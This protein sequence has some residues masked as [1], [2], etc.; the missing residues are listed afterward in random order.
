M[1]NGW[2]WALAFGM[3]VQMVTAAPARAQDQP[4]AGP[5]AAHDGAHGFD[6]LLGSWHYHLQR[7]QHPVT[8]STTWYKFDG[9]GSCYRLWDGAQ[10]DTFEVNG[11]AGHIEGITLRLYDRKTAQWRLY[12][13]NSQVGVLDPPQV[14]EFRNGHGDFFTQDTIDGKTILI[15]FDWTRM[16]SSAPH[17]E[18]AFSADG[19]TTWD[20]NWITDQ[21]RTADAPVWDPSHP[22]PPDA[23]PAGPAAA[24]DPQHDFD[25]DRG[26]WKIHIH[27]LLHPLTGSNEWTDMDGATVT[28][29][30]WNGRANLATVEA[31]G[32]T[33][34]L[35]LLSLRLYNPQSHQWRIYFDTSDSG[36]LGVPSIGEFHN[37]RGEF[38]DQEN[39]HGRAILVRFRI[40]ANSSDSL[41][42]DQAFSTDGGQTWETNWVNTITRVQSGNPQ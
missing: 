14:G 6:P 20:V 33:G 37:G 32:P 41:T 35:E 42:S 19:G 8:G 21:T 4:P 36:I 10:L 31:D 7:I 15:R 17:F 24:N 38:Y 18:Q 12:W 11:A 40:W 25:F 9:T 1:W 16:T 2:R 39:Y 27:R 26:T 5:P 30:I 23:P 29:D 22:A 3:L 13:A 28:R 34:H